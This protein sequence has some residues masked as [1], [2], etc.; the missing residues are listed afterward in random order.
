MDQTLLPFP[1]LRFAFAFAF[2]GFADD[3][4]ALPAALP[5]PRHPGLFTITFPQLEFPKN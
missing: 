2:P 4:S 5:A 1:S 3:L